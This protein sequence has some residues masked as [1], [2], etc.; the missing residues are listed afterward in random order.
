MRKTSILVVFGVALI[1]LSVP[2][3]SAETQIQTIHKEFKL[4]DNLSS[5]PN[6]LT[7]ENGSG[8]WKINSN[9][10]LEIDQ[11]SYFSHTIGLAI[12]N[13][14]NDL[15]F[16]QTLKVNFWFNYTFYVNVSLPPDYT[17]WGYM[18]QVYTFFGQTRKSG[19]DEAFGTIIDMTQ[20]YREITYGGQTKK[21]L[22]ISVIPTFFIS[23]KNS[24]FGTYLSLSEDNEM[25]NPLTFYINEH[26]IYTHGENN[27]AI[28]YIVYK[29][30]VDMKTGVWKEATDTG[31]YFV[32]YNITHL[33]EM[34][35][36]IF[37]VWGT[38]VNMSGAEPSNTQFNSTYPKRTFTIQGM[39]FDVTGIRIYNN[40]TG[41]GNNTGGN[42]NNGSNTGGN[43]NN[44]NNNPNSTNPIIGSKIK[45][46]YP[47][48][49]N[50]GLIL[51]I[52]IITMVIATDIYIH[53]KFP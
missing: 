4:P 28:Q 46:Y 50:I 17:H 16:N 34:A 1:M 26:F 30:V 52:V 3:V 21:Q 23:G 12:N 31:T 37:G 40:N 20:A 44:G 13:D 25:G 9:H 29:K 22:Q 8:N 47:L 43:G 39:N 27:S 45:P 5:I 24:D 36:P 14:T 15:N 19:V 42:G 35:Y 18:E 10:K 51:G 6:W 7:I 38:S 41:G 11:M 2:F 32:N 49:Y 53:R 33:G 48:T